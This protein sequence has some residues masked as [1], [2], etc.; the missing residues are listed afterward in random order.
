[1]ASQPVSLEFDGDERFQTLRKAL[2]AT[3]LGI[4][5]L[6]LAPRQRGRIHRHGQQ[7]EIY[8]VLQ[9]TLTVLVE[10]EPVEVATGQAL[11]VAPEERRQL[12]NA[13]SERCVLLALSAAGEHVGRDGEAFESWDETEG[14]PPQ[15]VALP[16]DL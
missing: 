5:L 1:M 12:V 14:H 8:V 4:N 7:E 13:G 16:G 2:G 10:Q 3:S 11:R 6:R 15:E 9:G